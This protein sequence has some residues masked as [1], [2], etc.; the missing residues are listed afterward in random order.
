MN[1]R[2]LLV[3]AIVFLFEAIAFAGNTI[4]LSG[5]WSFALDPENV[6]VENKWYLA[7]L[8]NKI[9]LPG[10]TDEA[11]FGDPGPETPE[12]AGVLTRRHE[13]LGVA[14]YVRE[15]TIDKAWS[16][17]Q[18][19]LTLERVMWRSD[20]WLDGVSIGDGQDSLSTSH[21]YQLGRLSPGKHIL[22]IRIDNRM[23]HPIGNK[24]HAYSEQT[25]SRWN[26]IVGRI[27]LSAKPL[28]H[29]RAVRVFTESTENGRARCE[30][31]LSGTDEGFKL[32]GEII[33]TD[34]DEV[35]G[36]SKCVIARDA[37]DL[38]ISC[39][40]P[41]VRWSEFN[42]KTYLARI[43]LTKNG[44]VCDRH[45][46]RFGFR[47]VS[48]DGNRLFINSK[49]V[50]M[51]GNLDCVHFVR[52]GYP[53][54]NKAQWLEIFKKYKQHNL[55][56]VR[57]HSWCP[58]EAAF[59]AAD[60]L[61]IYVQAEGP[62]WIDNWMTRPHSKPHMNTQGHP[63]G[64]G[65]ADRGVDEFAKAEFKRILDAYGNHPSFVFFCFGNELGASDFSELERWVGNLKEYDPRRLYAAS[66]ARNITDQCDFNITHLI[67]GVGLCRQ[68]YQANT[69]WDYQEQYSKSTV[70]IIV[71]EIGQWPIYPEWSIC[72]KFTG[73][74]RNRRLESLRKLAKENGVYDDQAAF[75]R[76]SGA[77]N[78]RLYKD[79]I[80]SFLRTP[81]CRGFQLLSMQDFQGQGEAYVGWLDCFWDSK[82]TT[83]TEAFR[84]YCRPVA[85]LARLP[86]YLFTEGEAIE[87]ELLIRN[88]GPA[89]LKD[90][91]LEV[92]LLDRSGNAFEKKSVCFSA[93]CGQ[94]VGAGKVAFSPEVKKAGRWNLALSLQG[95]KEK[96]VYPIWVYPKN[97]PHVDCPNTLIANDFD[98]T[99]IA[100]L[101]AGGNV[102]LDASRLGDA[103]TKK[104]A[105]WKPL[106]WST[107][108]FPGQN[109]ETLGLVVREDRAAYAHFPTEYF[110]DW[111]WYN[112][113]DN[114]R[115]F[116]LTGIVPAKYK[117][118]AQPVT[119]FHFNRKLGSIFELKVASGRLLVCG[120]DLS[121]DLPEVKQLRYSLLKYMATDKFEPEHKCDIGTLKT[122]F[123]N[124]KVA[125][126][127]MPA[128]FE[129]ASFY[130]RA[131]GKKS[132]AGNE[133]WGKKLDDAVV[134]KG[135]D[136]EVKAEGVW[137]D[138]ISSGWHGQNI[139]IDIA[140]P[141]GIAGE[142]YVCVH[143]WNN[144]GRRGLINFEGREL[145]TGKHD[146]SGKWIKFIV[147]RE[148]SIDGRLSLTAKCTAGHDLM[149]TSI[150]IFEKD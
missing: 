90:Q 50:F 105:H 69:N 64:L 23:I 75:T 76:S 94:L 142:L 4:D 107:C 35:L 56:H 144:L 110:N 36:K 143:D 65:K 18:I 66:T 138:A 47:T 135:F 137:K 43:V 57:F 15:I 73:V 79:E 99:V 20:V 106:Y 129:K 82:W 140:V 46:S 139:Q 118:I 108:H 31:K 74:L 62:I 1:R 29:I 103:T 100:K 44:R 22:A 112:I 25:Q 12:R 55:N 124:I 136:Y 42:P 115:G 126:S 128:G 132:K 11:G 127:N 150:A 24:N 7:T 19:S 149:I 10:T 97:L 3:I 145:G 34:N 68:R 38:Q 17:R 83:S 86:K 113:C 134:K 133:P 89:P 5:Q 147:M 72:E 98:E 54:T 41:V 67:P 37:V 14:W 70:P 84:G 53:A 141:E 63:Q 51:R 32:Y 87:C 6:G 109:T 52:T 58:P 40:E 93:R 95:D 148:D 48:R 117:P 96:N 120:Y 102:L 77:L 130:V 21:R 92:A 45:E 91:I 125:P 85:P 119:D 111:Q 71:H 131:A 61:G 26:G 104:N 27:E 81:D 60:E 30:I 33:D 122:M 49:P 28:C 78:A 13:Y 9:S 101:K 80:E 123:N 2:Y 121:R 114:A 8:P 88:D 59:D 146:G 16:D 116:D 39:D